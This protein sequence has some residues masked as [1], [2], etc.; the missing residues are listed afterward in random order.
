MSNQRQLLSWDESE[1][2]KRNGRLN[3]SREFV[4]R[5]GTLGNTVKRKGGKNSLSPDGAGVIRQQCVV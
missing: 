3:L 5:D 4:F 2:R 1:R